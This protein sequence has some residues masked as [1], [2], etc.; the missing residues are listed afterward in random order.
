MKVQKI[1]FSS[2]SKSASLFLFLISLLIAQGANPIF[3]SPGNRPESEPRLVP[4]SLLKWP[5]KTSDYAIL[6][7][8]SAQ[9]VFVYHRDHPFTPMK[10]YRGS[11]GENDGP[12]SIENDKKTPEGV[13]FFTHSYVKKDLA[14]IYGSRAF[15]IDYPNPMDKKNGRNG[16]GIWFHGTNK[17]LKPKD[18]NGCIALDNP[19]IDELASYIKLNDTPTIISS[20]IEM[21][22]PEKLQ[23]ETKELEKVIE[24]WRR[25]WEGKDIDQYMSSYSPQFTSGRKNWQQWKNY[26]QRLA[27]KYQRIKVDIDNLQLIKNDGIVLAK[28]N[29]LYRTA[30]FETYGEKRLYLHQTNNQWKIIGEF[31]R[32][33]KEKRPAPKQ[34]YFSGLGDIERL[35]SSWKKAWEEKDLKTY[36]SFYDSNFRSRGMNRKAWNRHRRRLNRKHRSLKIEI[37]DLKIV[38]VSNRRARVRFKQNYRADGYRDFGLKKIFLIKKGEH[39]KIKKEKWSSLSRKSR[40]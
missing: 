16:Y 7:D 25:S 19:A 15:P 17:P 6:V 34:P 28:F 18:T 13:Y 26:K 10:V 27:R 36:I 12:K 11:T 9:K 22:D 38:P 3:A 24:N 39:W 20:R 29:Q 33:A 30:R 4:A 21:V 32:G 37:T 1:F 2:K 31:F 5:E 14:P 8:K 35:I 40:P 23:E